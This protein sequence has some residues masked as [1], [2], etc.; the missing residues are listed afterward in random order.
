MGS[1]IN[2]IHMSCNLPLFSALSALSPFTL[3]RVQVHNFK[4]LTCFY[5]VCQNEFYYLVYY[6]RPGWCGYCSP[7]AGC[8]E[9]QYYYTSKQ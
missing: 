4:H 2:P 9:R 5:A 3:Y 7:F 1:Y 6:S 8:W